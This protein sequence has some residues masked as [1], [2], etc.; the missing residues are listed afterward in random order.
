VVDGLTS[1]C[2]GL[3]WTKTIS[4]HSN[5]ERRKKVVVGMIMGPRCACKGAS[6][7]RHIQS[8]RSKVATTPAG[9]TAFFLQQALLP[10]S[11]LVDDCWWSNNSKLR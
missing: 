2:D 7:G 3:G 9:D 8:S 11:C 10:L 4:Y 6:A 1:C 5:D